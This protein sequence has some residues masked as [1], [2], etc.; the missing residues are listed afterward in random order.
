MTPGLISGQYH[1]MI[2]KV[3]LSEAQANIKNLQRDFI[4]K[5]ILVLGDVGLDEYVTGNVVRISPEAPVPVLEVKEEF[6]RL[7]LSTNVAQNIKALGGEPLLLSSVGRDLAGD[8]LRALLSEAEISS[9]YLIQHKTRS[10]IR[11][12]R[13]MS[14]MHHIVRVDYEQKNNLDAEAEKKILSVYEDMLNQSSAVILQDYAKGLL[15]REFNT[16]VIQLAKAKSLPVYVDPHSSNQPETYQNAYL[17]TP[18]MKEALDLLRS[19]QVADELNENDILSI[20][21]SLQERMQSEA[22]IITRSK[23]GMTLFEQGRVLQVPTFAKQVYDVTGA[24]DTV[25]AAISMARTSGLSLQDACVFAN[26][27]AGIVVAK[28]GAATASMEEILASMDSH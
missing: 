10:T 2:E 28:V 17:M 9:E 25:I 15:S 24:G 4:G 16:K 19:P 5:K 1:C 3:N 13:M 11:K 12:T 22:M 23:D 14:G 20:G 8:K 7:G 27:A 21:K 6:Y 26:Y 18:N